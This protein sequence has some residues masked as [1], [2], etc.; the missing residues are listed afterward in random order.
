MR[1]HVKENTAISKMDMGCYTRILSWSSSTPCV[2]SMFFGSTRN[3]GPGLS[4]ANPWGAFGAM[5]RPGLTFGQLLNPPSSKPHLESRW[6]ATCSE[7]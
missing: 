3:G 7:M 5:K 4:N 1:S 6:W 2:A